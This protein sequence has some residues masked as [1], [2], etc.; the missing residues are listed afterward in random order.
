MLTI[1]TYI[2]YTTLFPYTVDRLHLALGKAKVKPEPKLWVKPSMALGKALSV[3]IVRIDIRQSYIT[4][5]TVSLNQ[6][7][8]GVNNFCS[9]FTVQNYPAHRLCYYACEAVWCVRMLCS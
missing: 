9:Y 6:E 2:N 4:L 5:V 1:N 7:C 3:V 8:Q